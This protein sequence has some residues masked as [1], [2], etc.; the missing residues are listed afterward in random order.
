MST[1]PTTDPLRDSIAKHGAD[2]NDVL[3]PEFDIHTLRATCSEQELQLRHLNSVVDRQEAQL[4]ELLKLVGLLGPQIRDYFSR[5]LDEHATAAENAIAAGAAAGRPPNPA[6]I[7]RAA[8]LRLWQSLVV[9][10]TFTPNLPNWARLRLATIA[11]EI[12]HAPE[13]PPAPEGP[14]DTAGPMATARA[15]G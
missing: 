8:T 11:E 10:K 12:R 9:G 15:R 3:G 7:E 5:E 13:S 1:P 14:R 6:L 2:P 4:D